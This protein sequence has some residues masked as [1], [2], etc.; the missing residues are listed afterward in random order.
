MN[1]IFNYLIPK[2]PDNQFVTGTVSSLSPLQVKLYPADYPITCKATT[3]LYGLK[4]GSN[5]VLMKIGNQFLITH[6]IGT[7]INT[8]LDS[9]MINRNST[10]TITTTSA[11]KVQFDNQKVIVGSRLSFDS[12]N[13]GVKIGAGVKTVEV[14]LNLWI[15]RVDGA[16]SY[17]QIYKNSTSYSASVMTKLSGFERW[18]SMSSTAL[19]NVVENDLIYG[20]ILFSSADANYNIIGGGYPNSC[21]LTVKAIELG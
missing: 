21:N 13:Y 9:I 8:Y 3:G 5:V 17:I 11:T 18:V 20:Y 14:N 7:Q 19:I 6:V 16:Y 12:G 1:S 2:R 4:V 10:Q 15:Q